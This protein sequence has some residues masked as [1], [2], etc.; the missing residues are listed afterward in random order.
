MRQNPVLILLFFALAGCGAA[1]I[2]PS[3]STRNATGVN[4]QIQPLT[5]QSVQ[6]A[7]SSTYLPKRLPAAFRQSTVVPGSVQGPGQTPVPVSTAQ[8]RPAALETRIPPAA[9]QQ[10]YQIGVGDVILLATPSAASTVEELSGLLAAQNKRQGYT[11]QDDGAIAIPDVGR[12]PLSG[13]SLEEA[14]AEIFQKLVANQI[15]PSFSL[16]IAEFNSKKVSIGGAVA[17]P[18]IAPISLTPL[19]LDQALAAAGGVSAKDQDFTVVRL[20][21]AGKL[22]QIPLKDMRAKPSLQKLR[23]MPGD[24]IFVDIEF[25]LDRAQAYFTEQITL[26]Q[27]RQKARVQALN[28]L[29]AEVEIRRSA[30]VEKRS[31]FLARLELQAADRDYVY[32]TGEVTKQNRYALP[33]ERKATLADALYDEGGFDSKTGNPSQIYV[34]R[35]SGSTGDLSAITAWHLDARNAVNLLLATRLELRPNDIIF[36]AEQPITRWNRVLSQFIPSLITSGV[37]ATTN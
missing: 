27:F 17:N 36:I 1:Y 21:R 12:I 19:Y 11:V 30:L 35:G 7:N 29:E 25:E 10:P 6:L 26:A 22:Y 4:V 33:F 31:N 28:E 14:E 18:T 20:Y 3:V 24:S 9:P 2:S 5:V 32:L 23:L 34:L 15:D 8:N 16:E 37:A 13:L